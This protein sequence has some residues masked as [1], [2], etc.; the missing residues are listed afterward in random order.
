MKYIDEFNAKKYDRIFIRVEKGK[1]Q[2]I[3]ER[4]ESKGL[5]INGYINK[6]IEEDK[7]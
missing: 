3:E 1:K 7:Q 2:E 5:S 4:A 6:L